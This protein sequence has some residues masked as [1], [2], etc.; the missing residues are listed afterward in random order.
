MD[1]VII[2][3]GLNWSST[4]PYYAQRRALMVLRESDL[5]SIPAILLTRE[6]PSGARVGAVVQCQDG[7][8]FM[9]KLDARLGP[10]PRRVEAGDCVLYLREKPSGSRGPP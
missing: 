7:Y 5:P 8:D 4:V 6:D 2:V 3:A 1:D 10:N 9:R